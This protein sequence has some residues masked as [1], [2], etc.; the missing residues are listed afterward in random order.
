[1]EASSP[2]SP[3]KSEHEF[4]GDMTPASN[5]NA[6]SHRMEDVQ[7]ELT[8]RRES[9]FLPHVVIPAENSDDAAPSEHGSRLGPSQEEPVNGAAQS[10]SD[11][12]LPPPNTPLKKIIEADSSSMQ[13]EISPA[14]V[15]LSYTANAFALA[16]PSTPPP[17]S[18]ARD[19]EQHEAT[20]IPETPAVPS[21]PVL[22]EIGA[23]PS[24]LHTPIKMS[25]RSQ[26]RSR[27]TSS[28]SAH[29]TGTADDEASDLAATPKANMDGTADPAPR[30]TTRSGRKVVQPKSMQESTPSPDRKSVV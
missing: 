19:T 21:T 17:A 1:M 9:S 24:T 11:D 4:C 20:E 6:H 22:S 3:V 16:R 28:P 2:L 10:P 27:K 7:I 5:G 14:H 18:S 15:P 30:T 26:A 29:K 12:A 23:T 25:P 8:P 13:V